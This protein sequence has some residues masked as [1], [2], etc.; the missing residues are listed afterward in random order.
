MSELSDKHFKE[1]IVKMLQ[2]VM[3]MLEIKYT[4][5]RRKNSLSGL[6]SGLGMRENKSQQNLKTDQQMAQSEEEG[7]D[8][9]DK[10]RISVN[11]DSI[12]SVILMLSE[13][14]KEKEYRALKKKKKK[15][16]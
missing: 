10:R 11:S 15:K 2:S 5:I 1:V 14:Q 8:K 3:E 13:F 4:V 12:K 7:E 9:T 16:T 6:N